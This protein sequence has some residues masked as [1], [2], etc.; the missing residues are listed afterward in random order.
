MRFTALL[1]LLATMF[2]CMASAQDAELQR[3]R[4]LYTQGREA[5]QRGEWAMC[6]YYFEQSFQLV[7]SPELLYNVGKCY[8]RAAMADN[9]VEY[10]ERALA[11]YTRFIRE[12]PEDADDEIRQRIGVLRD[13]MHRLFPSTRDQVVPETPPLVVVVP[14]ETVAPEPIPDAEDVQVT[15]PEAAAAEPEAEADNGFAWTW[16]LV[17]GITTAV[18]GAVALSVGSVARNEFNSLRDSCGGTTAGCDPN[19]VSRVESLQLA[20]N[21]LLGLSGALLI[22]TGLSF[23][24][25][26]SAQ[27]GSPTPTAFGL[28]LTRNF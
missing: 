18:M 23:I 21:I 28:Q 8:D 15:A 25:E 10:F 11:A 7:H 26:F 16:T 2:P 13:A 9:R 27:S 5:F 14:Q 4:D 3:A 19:D 6:A 12:R 1:L 17:G 20:T 22:G 24:F